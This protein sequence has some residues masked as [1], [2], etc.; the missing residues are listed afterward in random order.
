MLHE[1]PCL[2]SKAQL[3][4]KTQFIQGAFKYIQRLDEADWWNGSSVQFL[5]CAHWD[6]GAYLWELILIRAVEVVLFDVT[7]AEHRQGLSQRLRGHHTLQLGLLQVFLLLPDN[8]GHLLLQ[9]GVV[10][11]L[12]GKNKQKTLKKLKQ[13]KTSALQGRT[14][15][16]PKALQIFETHHAKFT[17]RIQPQNCSPDCF[18]RFLLMIRELSSHESLLTLHSPQWIVIEI[19]LPIIFWDLIFLRHFQFSE[20]LGHVQKKQFNLFPVSHRAATF[21]QMWWHLGWLFKIVLTQTLCSEQ[22]HRYWT[23]HLNTNVIKLQSNHLKRWFHL[24]NS[25]FEGEAPA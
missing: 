7:L 16:L 1:L 18:C 10:R 17:E 11:M 8:I 4:R 25:P 6:F 21:E 13:E 19:P 5:P 14:A 9:R 12:L 22:F 24:Q 20:L 2:Y 23:V 3:G 15:C